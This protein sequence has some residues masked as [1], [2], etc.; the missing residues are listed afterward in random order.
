MYTKYTVL[1]NCSQDFYYLEQVYDTTCSWNKVSLEFKK[2]WL[3]TSHRTMFTEWS[4]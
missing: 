2:S 3:V 4:G 1:E